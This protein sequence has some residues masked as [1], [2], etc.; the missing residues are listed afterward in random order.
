MLTNEQIQKMI[1][2]AKHDHRMYVNRGWALDG[3]HDPIILVGALTE[4]LALREALRWRKYPEEKPYIGQR[5]VLK[6][7]FDKKQSL[8]ECGARFSRDNCFITIE[9]DAESLLD[10]HY[11]L[12][13]P[14]GGE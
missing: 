9:G 7:I 2:Q 8:Y 6:Y 10:P 3:I 11:W 1:L 4:L 14:E 13:I 12:P 5:C